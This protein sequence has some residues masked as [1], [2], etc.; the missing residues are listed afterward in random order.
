MCSRRWAS[1]MHTTNLFRQQPTVHR[2]RPVE[3]EA[4]P[5]HDPVCET[6]SHHSHVTRLLLLILQQRRS[7]SRCTKWGAT[8]A[9]DIKGRGRGSLSL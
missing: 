1:R 6:S 4:G 9:S 5:L 2:A 3:R 7:P 8:S